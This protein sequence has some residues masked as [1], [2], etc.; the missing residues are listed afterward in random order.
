M[1]IKNLV[2]SSKDLLEETVEKVIEDFFK[3]S[4]EG[5]ILITNRDFWKLKGEERILRYLASAAGRQ[6]LDLQNSE[7]GLSNAQI[8][9]GLNMNNNSVRAN[10]SH[11]RAR[12]LVRMEEGKNSVTAQGLHD[13]LKKES[14]SND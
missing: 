14:E 12:G 2:V 9:K 7:K 4:E 3:Y 10:L 11:L 1:A 6:F 13:L 8:S 5:E